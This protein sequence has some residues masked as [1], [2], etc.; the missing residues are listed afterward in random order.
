MK[1]ED[2]WKALQEGG[3]WQDEPA[4][5]P[6]VKFAFQV[7]P[8]RPATGEAEKDLPLIAIP[9]TWRGAAGGPTSPL[10]SKL[11]QE[12]DLRQ[13]ANVAAMHPK[14][15]REAGV[16]DGARAMLQTRCGRCEVRVAVDAGVMP[17]VVRVAAG[18]ASP[19]RGAVLDVCG[20]DAGGTW[21]LTRAKVVRV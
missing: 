7:H 14:T 18:P 12:S 3:C 16:E 2:F 19:G 6:A 17:G 20:P 9:A 8:A 4:A 5:A 13:A 10:M 1:G 11:Y 21:R 15:A